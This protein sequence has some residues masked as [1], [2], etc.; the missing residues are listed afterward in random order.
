[1]TGNCNRWLVALAAAN[2]ALQGTNFGTFWKSATYI[3]MLVL[4]PFALRDA[5]SRAELSVPLPPRSILAPLVLWLAW[6]GLTWFWSIDPA[7]T[8][9]E[10]KVELVDLAFFMAVFY[11][12]PYSTSAWRTIIG[13]SLFA[14]ALLGV[15]A[16]ALASLSSGWFNA[17]RFHG[18]IGPYSTYLVQTAPLLLWLVVPAPEGFGG[19]ARTWIALG[20]ITLIL[21]ADARLTN[22]RIVWFALLLALVLIPAL[23]AW[24][25]RSAA[26]RAGWRWLV[27][28]LG[29][30]LLLSLGFAD[31]LRKRTELNYS[32]ST[33]VSEALAEDPRLPLWSR[34]WEKIMERP[35]AGYGAGKKILAPELRRELGDPLLTHAHNVF[36]SQWVQKGAVGVAAFAAL[37]LAV[38]VQ[39][40]KFFR[41]RDDV[42]ALVGITGL[43]IIA[44]M[45]VKNLTDD[46]L[47]GA[48]GRQFL[49][50]L[51]L[52]LGYGMRREHAAGAAGAAG[53]NS[54]ATSIAA[55]HAAPGRRVTCASVPA[56]EVAR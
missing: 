46:F 50:L 56:E 17:D 22:N 26:R 13:S 16:V 38:I 5:R 12:V 19:R 42:V 9:A 55:P 11:V 10:L 35:L 21:I 23:C 41:S 36:I 6:S 20:A 51:S 25:W 29:V 32:P 4:L 53:R 2:L 24:R 43:A 44:A 3:G 54:T 30:T 31:T 18:G 34:T 1:M 48:Y 39:F 8:R 49:C 45:I 47:Y 14:F 15:L 7:Y 40:V 37:L 28:I 33:P 52:L 27:P